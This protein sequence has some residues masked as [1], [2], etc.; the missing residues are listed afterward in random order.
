MRREPRCKV[1]CSPNRSLY[2]EEL[3]R[4]NPCVALERLAKSKGENIS[5]QSFHRHL[6]RHLESTIKKHN[7]SL[8]R[9]RVRAFF[10]RA[11]DFLTKD[12]TTF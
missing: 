1:C 9:S 2:E 5:L 4:G 7:V 3:L 6:R 8:K 11:F 12:Q 10:R